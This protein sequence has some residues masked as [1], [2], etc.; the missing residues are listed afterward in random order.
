MTQVGSAPRARLSREVMN[1]YEV[2]Y[3]VPTA[4][5]SSLLAEF[6]D[7]TRPD[8]Y[9][10]DGRGYPIFSIYWD[11]PTLTFFWEKVEGVKY[12]RKL[13]FRRYGSGR[14]VFVEVKQREDRTLQKRRLKWPLE[15]VMAAFGDGRTRVDWNALGDEPV[16][17]EVALMIE[18]LR[19]QPTMGILYRRRALFGAF[20]P[21][22]RITVDGRIQ[23]QPP[24]LDLEHPFEVGRYALDPRVSVLE[25]KFDH[26]APRW[27]MKTAARYGLSMVRMSKYCSAVDQ[28]R[29]DGQN[30]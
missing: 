16:A 26:R 24:P 10:L 23:Y 5:V 14:D 17:V 3:L 2:K 1:R 15:R 9:D 19:L 7:Y 6:A 30:T 25:V 11:T 18:R 8:P 20:D 12:R 27:F 22:L 4:R 29:F 21:E 13:R 28:Y